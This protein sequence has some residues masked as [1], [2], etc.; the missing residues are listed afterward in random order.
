MWVFRQTLVGISIF[1]FARISI[2]FS[3]KMRQKFYIQIFQ[4]MM[5][6]KK[7]KCSIKRSRLSRD[8]FQQTWHRCHKKLNPFAVFFFFFLIQAIDIMQDITSV[9]GWDNLQKEKNICCAV[10]SK[11]SESH[12]RYTLTNGKYYRYLTCANK[13]DAYFG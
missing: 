13:I 8:T 7:D 6:Q 11:Q 12:S 2:Q 3:I 10:L 5:T 4:I 1:H 9:I